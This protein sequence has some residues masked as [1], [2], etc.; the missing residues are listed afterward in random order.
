MDLN[1][2]IMDGMQAVKKMR[3]MHEM[4]KIDISRT[5]IIMH[6]AIQ[7]T[8]QEEDIFDGKCKYSIV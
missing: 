5:K 7:D 1:M 4:Q 3:K 8:I 2:P 6:S